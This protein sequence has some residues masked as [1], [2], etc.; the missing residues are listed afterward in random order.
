MRWFYY[1]ARFLVKLIAIFCIRCKVTGKKNIPRKGALLI[2]S[3]HLNNA[4][5]PLLSVSLK[6]TTWFMAKKE[7][8]ETGWSNY[9]ISG[10]GAFP[11]HRG[12]LDRK[13]LR[14]SEKILSEGKALVMFPEASRSKNAQLQQAFPGS[15]L[16]AVRSGASILPVGISGTE[17]M[18]GFWPIRLPKVKVNIGQP[19]YLPPV[20]GKVTG[21]KLDELTDFIMEHIAELLP[22]KYR[23]HYKDKVRTDDTQG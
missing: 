13:A 8:F 14:E 1:V 23:G 2:V 17:K 12:K 16:I 3:N 11:V 9:F 20:D 6:R 18:I 22:E 7:L 21:E 10:F 15:A 4:D 19:F 5:P